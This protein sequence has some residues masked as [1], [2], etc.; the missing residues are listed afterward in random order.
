MHHDGSPGIYLRE[1]ALLQDQTCKHVGG[2]LGL[3]QDF[4][5]SCDVPSQMTW[6]TLEKGD[7]YLILQTAMTFD[8]KWIDLKPQVPCINFHLIHIKASFGMFWIPRIL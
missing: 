3:V 8:T 6:F 1:P 2:C 7:R 4:A 5:L